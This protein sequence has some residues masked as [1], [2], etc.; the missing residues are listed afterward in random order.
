MSRFSSPQPGGNVD[1]RAG[2]V[3]VAAGESRRMEGVDK[4]FLPIHGAPLLS[5]TLAAFEAVPRI[6]SIVLVLAPA[7]MERGKELVRQHGFAKVSEVCP[8]GERRQDSVRLGLERLAPHPWVVI[9]DGARPCVEPQVIE[10]GLEEAVRWG[11]VVAAVPMKDPVKVVRGQG[12]VQETLNR[13]GLWSVQT[14]QVFPW[15]VLHQTHQQQDVTV[16]DDA[17]LVE[18]LGYPVHVYFGSYANI[19]VTT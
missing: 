5:H 3:I 4:L 16:T 14:P 8:G 15:E 11:S 19:K 2:A 9:H 13:R 18:L 12:E 1:R 6:Q 7:N 17:A 10:R